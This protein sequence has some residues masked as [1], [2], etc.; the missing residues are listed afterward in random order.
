MYIM[1]LVYF[2]LKGQ[3]ILSLHFLRLL[4]QVNIILR[5]TSEGK[6]YET[7]VKVNI[8]RQN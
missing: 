1:I 4:L 8:M 3:I 6:Y 5:D 7:Q 2:A